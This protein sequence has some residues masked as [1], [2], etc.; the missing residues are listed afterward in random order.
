MKKI[1]VINGPNLN[2]LGSREPEKY[3]NNTLES[4]N[5]NL[6]REAASMGIET[7]FF[8]DNCEGELVTAIQKAGSLDG[9]ILNAG[10]YTHYSIAIRDAIASI[11]APV[12]E[13]HLTN[14]HK[15]EE[16]RHVSVLSAVCAGCILGFGADSYMLALY[17]HARMLGKQYTPEAL[18]YPKTAKTV[19]AKAV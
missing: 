14:I 15:R 4:I 13:V 3:G 17:A 2:M 6:A 7:T 16:F 1:L 18:T 12:I 5:K 19:N 8:Q 10:A 11:N 9:I